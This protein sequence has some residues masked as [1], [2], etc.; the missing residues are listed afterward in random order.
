MRWRG[1][2]EIVNDK[3]ILSSERMLY[4]DYDSRCSIEKKK[5][6]LAVGLKGLSAKTN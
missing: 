2:A 3:P 5:K 6:V 1:P 4:T